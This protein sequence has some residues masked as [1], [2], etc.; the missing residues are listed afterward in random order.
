MARARASGERRRLQAELAGYLREQDK[1]QLRLLRA[2]IHAARVERRHMVHGARQ[3]CREARLALRDQQQREREELTLRQRGQRVEE[4]AACA[5]GRASARSRGL[6]R[7]ALAAGE[8]KEARTL[9]RQ[10][11]NADRRNVVE[12]STKRERSQEDDDR[13]RSNLPAELVPVFNRVAK[14]IKGSAK[15]SRTEAFLEWAEEN[16]DEIIAVQQAEADAAL[17]AMLKEQRERGRVMRKA[18]RYKQSPEEL[19]E[20]LA[21]VPF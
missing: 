9:Q 14:R 20:L 4:R 18:G 5:S 21:A 13:V 2:R 8:F 15:R 10:V 16:P 19:R 6:E 17:R 3:Q 12:R 11:R 7:E 1:A